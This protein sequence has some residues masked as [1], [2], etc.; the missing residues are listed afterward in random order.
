MQF[1][2][3]LPSLRVLSTACGIGIYA[4]GLPGALC[5]TVGMWIDPQLF[6]LPS[7][8]LACAFLACFAGMI[9]CDVARLVARLSS[10]RPHQATPGSIRSTVHSR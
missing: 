6:T 2:R 5:C 9:V 7:A 3:S 1:R 4:T 8:L 10:H